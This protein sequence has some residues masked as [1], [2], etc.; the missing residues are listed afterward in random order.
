MFDMLTSATL[1][2]IVLHITFEPFPY[3]QFFDSLVGGLHSRVA[4]KAVEWKAAISLVLSAELSDIQICEPCLMM[5][6]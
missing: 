1:L 3:E 5:P 6:C 4:P 2:D